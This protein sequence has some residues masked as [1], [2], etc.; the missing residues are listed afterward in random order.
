MP[1]TARAYLNSIP[2]KTRNL[3]SPTCIFCDGSGWRLTLL[4][5]NLYATRCTHL[6]PS[7]SKSRAAGDR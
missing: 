6:P 2:P 5:G 3:G 4:N 1:A 7:D